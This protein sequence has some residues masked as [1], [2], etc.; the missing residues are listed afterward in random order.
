MMPND[1]VGFDVLRNSLGGLETAFQFP[2]RSDREGESNSSCRTNVLSALSLGSEFN[3]TS[4]RLLGELRGQ[5]ER[6]PAMSA[7][8]RHQ[9]QRPR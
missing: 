7:G 5:R 9:C 3:E 1:M 2:F 6:V 4:A 8:I